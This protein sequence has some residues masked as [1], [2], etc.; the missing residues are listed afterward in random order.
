MRSMKRKKA[1]TKTA[2]GQRGIRPGPRELPVSQAFELA[3][4]YCQTGQTQQAENIYQQI[5]LR[6][7]DN[8]QAY[9]LLG[10]LAVQA[11]NME[12]AIQLTR[13]AIEI[14]PDIANFHYNLGIMLKKQGRLAEAAASYRQAIALKPDFDN[15]LYNL[16]NALQTD[17]QFDEAIT[18]YRQVVAIRPGHAEAYNNLGI[19]LKEAGRFDEANFYFRQAISS[20]PDFAEAH[21][22]LGLLLQEMRQ[23][24]EAESCQRRALVLKPDLTEAHYNL[25]IILKKKGQ[26]DEAIECYR[27]ALA[28]EPDACEVLLSLANALWAIGQLDE[29]LTCFRKV[30]AGSPD[31]VPA[32]NNVLLSAQYAPVPSPPDLFQQYQQFAEHFEGPLKKR[33]EVHANT[34]D[35]QRKLK[36]GYVSADFRAHSVAYFIEPILANHSRVQVEIFCYYNNRHQDDITHRLAACADHWIPCA[37][38]SDEQLVQRIRADRIDILVDLSGHTDGNRLLVFAGKPAPVQVTWIGYPDTTGL[39]AMD[40]RLTDDQADPTGETEQWHSETLFRLPNCFLCFAP[41][42]DSPAI[43]PPPAAATGRITFASFNNLTKVNEATIR[44]WATILR[45][46]PTAQLLLKSTQSSCASVRNRLWHLFAQAGVTQERI[47][48]AEYTKSFSEH[49]GLYGSVDIALDTFPYNGTTTTCE[50]LWMGVPVITLAGTRHVA[51]V[52][53]SILSTIGLDECIAAS[54]EEYVR[55]AVTLARDQERL[56]ALRHAMRARITASP[57]CDAPGFTRDLENAYRTM[58]QTWCSSR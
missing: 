42:A 35:P 11:G 47:Q 55:R 4:S 7:P 53:V 3:S 2:A 36:I 14:D 54:E 21:S 24:D 16:G 31:N 40:Y 10:I 57:L 29:A 1:K 22:N 5:L 46:L 15:A 23:L 51:R 34:P 43:A 27:K 38:M 26:F 20:A 45:E 30:L 58:W 56:T 39:T 25:G 13:K 49:L 9:S 12:R 6:D 48:F 52:G 41:P 33:W 18:C 19:L 32:F 8:A 44:V 17:G 37:A 50:A 28:L